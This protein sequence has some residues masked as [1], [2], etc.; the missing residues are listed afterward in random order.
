MNALDVLRD[1]AAPMGQ[2]LIIIAG[3]GLGIGAVVFVVRAGWE[4]V[5]DFA[6]GGGSGFGSG[7][8]G[9]RDDDAAW[10]GAAE[11]GEFDEYR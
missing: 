10:W 11:S 4:L 3:V 9:G 6:S 5:V 2:W 7:S 1:A 8:A